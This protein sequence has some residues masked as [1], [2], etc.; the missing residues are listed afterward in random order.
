VISDRDGVVS[1]I[2]E[3]VKDGFLVVG[4]N[5]ATVSSDEGYYT[6]NATGSSEGGPSDDNED[7]PADQTDISFNIGDIFDANYSMNEYK[8]EVISDPTIDGSEDEVSTAGD[9]VSSNKV[10]FKL[11]ED[12][13]VKDSK[14][15]IHKEMPEIKNVCY[16]SRKAVMDYEGKYYVYKQME[17]GNY[18]AVNVTVGGY[19]D[20]LVIIK[21][22]L[23]EGD[24]VSISE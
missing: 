7:V 23:E 17:D 8:V 21:E 24:V 11:L 18:H 14:L 3:S 9:A 2:D 15:T 10:F 12:T 5:I 20:D 22:G 19:V 4:R 1:F 16:V 13:S 6:L